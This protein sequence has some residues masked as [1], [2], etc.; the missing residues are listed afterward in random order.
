MA[1]ISFSPGTNGWFVP[2]HEFRR[3][4]ETAASGL[5]ERHA[6]LLQQAIYLDGLHFEFLDPGDIASIV[7]AL[8]R[9]SEEI[10]RELATTPTADTRDREFGVVLGELEHRL[11]AFTPADPHLDRPSA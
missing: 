8:Q 11:G 2:R 5:S 9:A 4:L 10:R 1:V 3:L 6:L 7:A